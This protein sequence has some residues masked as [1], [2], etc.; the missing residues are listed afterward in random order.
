MVHPSTH[1]AEQMH[2]KLK[3]RRKDCQLK[4]PTSMIKYPYDIA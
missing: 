4:N 2:L 1:E 3:P